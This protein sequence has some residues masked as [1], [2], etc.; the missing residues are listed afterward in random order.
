MLPEVHLKIYIPP[1]EAYLENS[2]LV[3]CIPDYIIL[4]GMLANQADSWLRNANLP[5]HGMLERA[6]YV[7]EHEGLLKAITFYNGKVFACMPPFLGNVVKLSQN[8]EHAHVN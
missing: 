3:G 7:Y 8:A 1:G 5:E 2:E 4:W 6:I